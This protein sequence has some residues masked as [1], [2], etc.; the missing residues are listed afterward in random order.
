LY[1]TN[2]SYK[3]DGWWLAFSAAGLTHTFPNLVHKI[4]YDTP[5]GS[6]LPLTHTFIPNNLKSA[7]PTYMDKFTQEE[8]DAGCFDRPFSIKEAHSILCGHFS[9]APLG[10]VKKPGSTALRLINH[11]SKEDTFRQSKNGWQTC[12]WT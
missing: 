4:T 10:L 1:K 9:I 7:N 3:P 12:W 6:L 8:L 11:H 2:T 5:I